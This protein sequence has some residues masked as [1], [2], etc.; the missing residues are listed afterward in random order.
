VTL[1][2]S[3]RT[4]PRAGDILD[5]PQV[6]E[7]SDLGDWVQA[8]PVE[9]PPERIAGREIVLVAHGFNVSFEEGV[10][11]LARLERALGLP[12]TFVFA[13]VLWPGDYWVPVVNYPVEADDAV[14]CGALL[15][16]FARKHL[17]AAREL[18]F[19]SHSLGGRLVLEAVKRLH[20]PAREVCLLAAAVDDDCLST[21]QY[22][23]A[24]SNAKRISVVASR[25]DTVLHA[26]YPLGDFFS[27]LFYDA[28]S[29]RR[30]ALGY[31]GPR[32]V[33][34]SVL[35]AQIGGRDYGHSDY[36]PSSSARVA[37][38]AKLWEKPARFVAE[39]LLGTPHEWP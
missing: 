20:R 31:H 8:H 18:S 30:K 29:P 33:S 22:Q 24:L 11:A 23:A 15:A 27:D 17:A 19:V 21:P 38:D 12:P 1:F 3:F 34:S 36:L 37:S 39:T 26:A 13:G 2:L 9:L 7:A 14:R 28:D 6:L 35:H 10:R 5:T 32:P 4:S 16:A 25:G